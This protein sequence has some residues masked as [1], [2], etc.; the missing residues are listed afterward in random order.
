MDH[1]VIPNADKA[2]A[3]PIAQWLHNIGWMPSIAEAKRALKE[4][5]IKVNKGLVLTDVHYYIQ[6]KNDDGTPW[7]SFMT[8]DQLAK[9]CGYE[10]R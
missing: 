1:V 6:S 5:S 4:R 7:V 2:R 9:A 10:P 3:T 8:I